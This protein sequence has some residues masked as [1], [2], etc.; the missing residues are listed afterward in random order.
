MYEGGVPA[1]LATD[2]REGI[3]NV[4]Q[5]RPMAEPAD[6]RVP[7]HRTTAPPP[8]AIFLRWAGLLATAACP[9]TPWLRRTFNDILRAELLAAV[10]VAAVMTE[11]VV[12]VVA[13]AV[14]TT[15]VPLVAVGSC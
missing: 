9:G 7:G 1:I 3:G 6:R 11:M 14:A 4:G 13:L 15:I 8:A 2:V 5:T 10:A 12:V